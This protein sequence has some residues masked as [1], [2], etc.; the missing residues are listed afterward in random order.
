[1]GEFD[2]SDPYKL[3]DLKPAYGHIHERDIAGYRFFGYGDI[4]IVY[5][6]ISDFYTGKLVSIVV[7]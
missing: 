1:M 4:D 2:P 6:Q 7:R 3:C 5:G